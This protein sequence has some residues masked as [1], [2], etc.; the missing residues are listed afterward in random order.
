LGSGA[1]EPNRQG[2]GSHK[3]GFVHP[4]KRVD[5]HQYMPI[6]PTSLARVQSPRPLL[7][8]RRLRGDEVVSAAEEFQVA[9]KDSEER[10]IGVCPYIEAPAIAA[11]PSISHPQYANEWL[12]YTMV[13]TII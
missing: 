3:L 10:L 12:D 9:L 13:K 8:K 4:C 5:R 6:L 2:P 1:I 11:L 7:D